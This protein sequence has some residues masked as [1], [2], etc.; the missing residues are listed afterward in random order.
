MKK[1]VLLCPYFGKFP[2]YFNYFLLSC[3][4]NKNYNW[5]IFTDISCEELNIPSNVTIYNMTFEE[6]KEII[7]QK[8][9]FK[10]SLDRAYKLCDYKP[11]YG[12]IFK[13]YIQEYDFWGCCDID[14]IYGNLD[15]F[16]SN[17]ITNYDKI[18]LS[19]HFTLYRN[20]GFNNLLFETNL[21]YLF[22][23]DIIN[24][25]TLKNLMTYEDILTSKD[26]LVFDEDHGYFNIHY[27][28]EKLNLCSYDNFS[29]IAD[30]APSYYNLN[31]TRKIDN[32]Y[33]VDEKKR[34]IMFI[35]DNGHLYGYYNDNSILK[36]EEFMYAHLQKR[37][38]DIG[39]N[40]TFNEKNFGIVP[41]KF[42]NNMSEITN[43]DLKIYRK[44]DKTLKE[45]EIVVDKYKNMRIGTDLYREL[46]KRVRNYS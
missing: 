8:F 28:Y 43:N 15:S 11:A 5:I 9:D 25:D 36:K 20:T 45:Y 2:N 1:I 24:Y 26:I 44:P 39:N 10:I 13:E 42:I 21:D 38:M 6:L 37:K 16:I 22:N 32:Y 17:E 7:Q 12:Y 19:G 34:N 41:N 23:K 27:I 31:L 35:W 18:F 4:Y 3:K 33:I 14:V 30:V 46:I 40:F 29:Y